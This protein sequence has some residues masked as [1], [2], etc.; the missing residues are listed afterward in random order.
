MATNK[1]ATIRYH[2]LDR[3]FSN[4]GRRFFM[5]DLMEACNNAI[6][7]ATGSKDGVKRRQ[8]YNDINFMESEAGWSIPL[9]RRKEGKMVFYRYTD[10]SFSIRGQ[11]VNQGEVEQIAETL[12]IL[13]RFKGL[14]QFE[15]MD[16]I[17]VRLQDTFQTK[18]VK[19]EVVSFEENPYLQGLSFFTDIFQAISNQQAL[20]ITYQGFNQQ[21][22]E[23]FVFHPWYLKQYNNR[24]FVLGRNV[25]YESLST[26][27]IDRVQEVMPSK[28]TYL[29]NTDVDF[30]AYFDDVIGVSIPVDG[31]IDTIHLQIDNSLWPYVKSKPIHGSQKKKAENQDGVLIELRLIVNYE[32]VSL[33][34]SFMDRVE[35]LKPQSLRN[36]LYQRCAAT[37]KKYEH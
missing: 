4:T 7:E 19:S 33:L 21:Q 10:P 23:T 18:E 26:L 3:C 2:T 31:Q 9:E 6:Y 25:N 29:P 30:E 22:P 20:K 11:G 1:H 32:L 36:D 37:L 13:S 15:W 16:E 5:N 35:V 24:W 28:V 8:I 14:P 17:R 34:A 27:A 12:T